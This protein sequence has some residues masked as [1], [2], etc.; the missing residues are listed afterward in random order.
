[1]C[2][3]CVACLQSDHSL[4]G[5]LSTC[6]IFH[7]LVEQVL[8]VHASPVLP[9]LCHVNMHMQCCPFAGQSQLFRCGLGLPG[10]R[11]SSEARRS[12]KL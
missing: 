3:Q 6:Q 4:C 2:R 8:T 10:L 7:V 5:A 12:L 1:M 11:A 9:G